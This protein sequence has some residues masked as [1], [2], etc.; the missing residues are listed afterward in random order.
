[1][2][3]VLYQDTTKVFHELANPIVGH[4]YSF[5]NQLESESLE[6]NVSELFT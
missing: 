6:K 4:P 3:A 5:Y 2:N 1:M